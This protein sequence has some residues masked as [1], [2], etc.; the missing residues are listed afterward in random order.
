MSVSQGDA[1]AAPDASADVT[2]GDGGV[3]RPPVA[4]TVKIMVLGSSNEESTCW[5]A[6]LWRKLHAAGITNFDFVGRNKAGPACDVPGY[7]KDSE[8]HGGTVVENISADAWLTTFEA[9]P[10]D[11]ILQHN[12]G[13]DLLAGHPFAN[14]IDAYT[15][16]VKQARAVNPHV[17]YFA[18][19]HTPQG[20]AGN[21]KDVVALNAAMVP[22]A[23][24]ITS[25]DSP[26]RLVDLFTGIDQKTDM[27]DG[28]HLNLSGS[29]KVSDRFMAV[30]QPLLAPRGSAVESK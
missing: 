9:N 16:S 24:G 18:A 1:A 25:K 28:T 15:L 8:A 21:V 11:I 26:V 29:E 14:V 7:D 27:S 2:P 30:L 12:G 5:R 6:F 10:P 13:A 20:N 17:I 19:Q 22:W 4:G 3:S 23:A